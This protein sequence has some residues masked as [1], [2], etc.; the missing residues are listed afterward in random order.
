[1]S[2]YAFFT[3]QKQKKIILFLVQKFWGYKN[4]LSENF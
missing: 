4:L 1:M 3:Q 2:I